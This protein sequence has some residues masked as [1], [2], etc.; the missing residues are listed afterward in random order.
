MG[1][2]KKLTFLAGLKED[3]IVWGPENDVSTAVHYQNG[4]L[5]C[6]N[7]ILPT[8]A[9]EAYLNHW[10]N[11][12][13]RYSLVWT[14]KHPFMHF[15]D[16]FSCYLLFQTRHKK[17]QLNL[18]Q[19]K[20]TYIF[21]KCVFSPEVLWGTEPKSGTLTMGSSMMSLSKERRLWNS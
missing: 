1:S 9:R 21:R 13:I 17:M 4:D 14:I 7:S 6:C 5:K 8:S 20:N 18:L 12:P 16:R 10:V 11:K 2:V 15:S 19:T 3:G